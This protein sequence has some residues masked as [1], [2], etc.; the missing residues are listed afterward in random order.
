MSFAVIILESYLHDF[1]QIA[2]TMKRLGYYNKT[3][4]KE[5]NQIEAQIEQLSEYPFIGTP[6]SSRITIPNNYRYMLSANYIQF[7][8]VDEKTKTVAIF[9]ILH[10]RS[11]YLVTLG[12]L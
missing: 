10:K 5:L 2:F 9:R 3:I 12:L 11:N 6:L 7:Y 8:Q 1:D 4:V